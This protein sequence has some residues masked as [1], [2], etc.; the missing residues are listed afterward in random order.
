MTSEN[1]E[2]VDWDVVIAGA[3]PVGMALAALLALSRFRVLI[4][5]KRP[6]RA[7]MSRA[8]GITPP[9]L[10]LLADLGLDRACVAAGQPIQF[11][12]VHGGSRPLCDLQFHD[13]PGAHPYILSLPQSDFEAILETHLG[14]LD[15]VTLRREVEV[16]GF[17]DLGDRIR[18][19]HS[20]PGRALLTA[21][22]LAVCDGAGSA[23][24]DATG[25]RVSRRQ[26]PCRFAMADFVDRSE[27][28]D[29][30]HLFFT[31]EGTIESFP[32]PGG[33]RRWIAQLVGPETED[34]YLA[35]IR[36]RAGWAPEEVDRV[37]AWSAFQP[38]WLEAERF[39]HGR[40]IL[41]GDAAHVMSPIGGQGMNTGLAAAARLA[42]ALGQIRAGADALTALA[43]YER[44]RRAAF[45]HAG[46]FAAA[47]MWIGTRR[48]PVSSPIRDG[49]IRGLM[50]LRPVRAY[51]ARRFAM[52]TVPA[53]AE[54]SK[55]TTHQSMPDWSH[56]V[57]S[58]SRH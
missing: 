48:G 29:Q 57:S 17:D 53:S 47:C 2:E 16:T 54:P 26:Y 22:W 23:I 49:L 41:C 55:A 27:F 38:Q 14:T 1:A 52:L 30:A 43:A 51:L 11:A 40:A 12:M 18:I 46:E 25:L 6:L 13:L 3:G 24:R 15:G 8:I 36:L 39:F 9:S 42:G 5:E 58:E 28:K 19:H 50:R 56:S 37:S 20:I 21:R 34:D 7:A 4:L 33:Q 44:D 32:L 10:N 31:R 45:R 35:A